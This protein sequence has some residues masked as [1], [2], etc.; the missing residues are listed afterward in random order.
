MLILKN[1]EYARKMIKNM[2]AKPSTSVAHLLRVCCNCVMVLLK[3][4]YL[5]SLIHA[6]NTV[7][8]TMCWY[9]TVIYDSH[10]KSA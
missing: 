5:K 8:A 6:K 3:E 9:W 1:A 4:M 2:T 10:S 7:I